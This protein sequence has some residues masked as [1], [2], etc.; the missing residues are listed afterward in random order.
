[1]IRLRAYH[2]WETAG[3]PPGDGIDFWLEAEEE[4]LRTPS[5]AVPL[6]EI[7]KRAYK[8]W[9][10]AGTPKHDSVRFWLEAEHE[11]LQAT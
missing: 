7:A 8:K 1:M 3:K 11:L 10:A 5:E 2:K 4:L 6:K 9:V